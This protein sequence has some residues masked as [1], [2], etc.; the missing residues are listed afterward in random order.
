[1]S[2]MPKLQKTTKYE[3]FTTHP[4]NRNLHNGAKELERSMRKTGFWPSKAIH[5][6]SNMQIIEGHNRYHVAKK[7]NIPLY[8]IVDES[9]TDIRHIEGF[10]HTL[11]NSV[12]YAVANARAGNK[13][14]IGLLDFAAKYSLP[15][16]TAAFMLMGMKSKGGLVTESI[17]TGNFKIKDYAG[18]ERIA[19]AVEKMKGYGASF[20]K[21][22][23]F[24]IAL[25]CCIK[26]VDYFSLDVLIKKVK[27]E[28]RRMVKR[29]TRD[30]YLEEIEMA[31]NFRNQEKQPI[32][33]DALVGIKNDE[34]GFC[35][36]K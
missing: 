5:V 23:N 24:I 1:M 31:Y 17:R 2:A 25:S 32:K 26:L 3:L 11:W 27:L 36:K 30:D 15:I 33:H 19:D 28:P 14:Y 8:Y 7:L 16:T 18:A 9:N 12:D 6:D 10:K 4:Y 35:K 21:E 20:S 29:S 22:R 13:D 34:A